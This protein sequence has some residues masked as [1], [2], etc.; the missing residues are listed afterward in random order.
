MPVSSLRLSTHANLGDLDTLEQ[1]VVMGSANLA[2]IQVQGVV[3]G[4]LASVIAML[5]AWLGD[6]ERVDL[7]KAL[8]MCTSS[9]V[10]ASLASFILGIVMVIVIASKFKSN[11]K[12]K[13]SN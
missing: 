7:A 6:W 9:V 4:A 8:L 10:T 11:T 3:V 13:T 5:M 1:T 2:L 12:T